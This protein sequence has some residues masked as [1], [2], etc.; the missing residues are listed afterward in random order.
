MFSN[1]VI[2]RRILLLGLLSW[3]LPFALSFL[4]FDQT[5][6][7]FVP[8]ML[9]KSLMV[10]AGGGIGV[11]LLVVAFRYID[12]S[13]RSGLIIGCYWLGLNLLFDLL[14]LVPMS[15]MAVGEYFYDIG[16]RYLLLPII[17]T[18]MG[19]VAKQKK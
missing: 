1:I 18:A 14:I 10:V 12:A 9:F 3:F 4:F 5:G 17:A 7:L 8:R 6:Q 13:L 2:N 15:G 11:G 19:V 16:L